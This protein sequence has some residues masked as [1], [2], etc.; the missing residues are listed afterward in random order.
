MNGSQKTYLRMLKSESALRTYLLVGK[1][2]PGQL[3]QATQI[4]S[5][6]LSRGIGSAGIKKSGLQS[7]GHIFCSGDFLF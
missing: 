3:S 7:S 4:D 2:W 1:L 6:L 5:E